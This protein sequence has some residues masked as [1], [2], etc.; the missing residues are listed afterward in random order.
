MS[1]IDRALVWE[2]QRRYRGDSRTAW[3]AQP[4]PRRTYS[5]T[6]S[7][8]CVLVVARSKGRAMRADYA[9]NPKTG[10]ELAQKWH[11]EFMARGRR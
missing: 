1:G 3:F 8:G 10:R 6:P 9:D 11:G 5:V 4:R 2:P 7:H